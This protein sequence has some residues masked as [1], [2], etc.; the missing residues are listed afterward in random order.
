[1][2]GLRLLVYDATCTGGRLPVGLSHSWLA[3]KYLYA[4][5][6]RL[7][8][9]VGVR[10]WA[11]A[12]DWLGSQKQCIAEVQYWGHGRW[13]RALVQQDVLDAGAL[14]PGHPLH[15]KL[16]RVRERLSDDALWWFRTCDAFGARR[17]Q[18]FARAWTD[19]MG[20]DAAGHTHII[21]V[22][23]S[24]LHRLSPGAQPHWPALEGVREG[25]ADE[26]SLS[27]W[28][29]LGA[30]CTISCLTGRIPAGY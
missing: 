24:G 10:S 26:P 14:R 8:G 29:K 7:D 30:P 27:T 15:P 16:E 2:S 19:F 17:G 3:G 28:S 23:Q 9:A 12:L 5:L 6:G 25:S 22:W 1:M 18:D 11:E 4:G 20:R 21:G 13:G